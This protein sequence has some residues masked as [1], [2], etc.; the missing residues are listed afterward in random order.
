MKNTNDMDMETIYLEQN[1]GNAEGRIIIYSLLSTI[2]STEPTHDMLCALRTEEMLTTLLELGFNKNVLD[3]NGDEEDFL[4]QLKVE[5]A[6]LFEENNDF[7]S[8]PHN[9]E[10]LYFD[11]QTV[12][13]ATSKPVPLN[14]NSPSFLPS[15]RLTNHKALYSYISAELT[16]M[17]LLAEREKIARLKENNE[18]ALRI[19]EISRKF[20]QAHLK[21]EAHV[22]CDKVASLS[23]IPFYAEFARLTNSFIQCEMYD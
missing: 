18:E 11:K 22:L 19:W 14:E 9:Y 6:S 16:Y 8:L 15:A 17:R 3:S 12:Q 2:F 4:N 23:S 20:L 1:K 10:S 5:F 7:L 21:R 13:T